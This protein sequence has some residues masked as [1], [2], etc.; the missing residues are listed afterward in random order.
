MKRLLPILLLPA[1]LLFGACAGYHLGGG[2]EPKFSRLYV[3]PVGSDTLLPQAS[4]IVT[5]Q[6]R[7]AF[8]KDGRVTLVDA[9]EEADAVLTI[10]LASYGRE[11]AVVRTD[12]TGLARRFDVT[13][14][15]RATLTDRRAGAA[16]FS[17][18][19]LSVKR[20]VFTDGGQLQSEYQA[21]PILA[22]ELARQT[23]HATLD[24]W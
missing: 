2:S 10:K 13:L 15:A 20:G 23:V 16:I 3:G 11:T 5:T 24:T 19:M 14:R 9:A 7:E 12:D 4:A 18:R 6:I 17:E 21:L 22:E 1:V 8:L